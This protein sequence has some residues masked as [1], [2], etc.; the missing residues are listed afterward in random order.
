MQIVHCFELLS[1]VGT[2]VSEDREPFGLLVQFVFVFFD[3]FVQVMQAVVAVVCLVFDVDL[4]ARVPGGTTMKLG[5]WPWI[6]LTLCSSTRYLT[7]SKLPEY[8]ACINGEIPNGSC[9]RG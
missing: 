4:R 2:D 7:I 5:R 3:A 1:T 8:T 9:Q 6:V